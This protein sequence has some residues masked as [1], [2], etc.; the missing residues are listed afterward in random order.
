MAEIKALNENEYDAWYPLWQGYLTFYEA[1]LPDEI[2]VNNWQRFHDPDQP[3]FALG[4][5]EDG[6][7]IGFVH[8]IYHRTNWAINDTCYLQDLYADPTVRGSGVGRAL[9]EAVYAAAKEAGSP[10]VYWIT[11]DHNETAR[12]LYDRI[13]G[14]SG[15]VHYEKEL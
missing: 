5:Y 12:K 15:F 10:D 9:I 1:S 13:A 8:Y 7:L 14:L 4:A 6:K 11:Q 3:V 2:A